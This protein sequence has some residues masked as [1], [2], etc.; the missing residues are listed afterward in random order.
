MNLMHLGFRGKYEILCNFSVESNS[1]AQ[2][3]L[4]LKLRLYKQDGSPNNFLY[5]EKFEFDVWGIL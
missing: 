4:G 2:N 3:S 5:K 1:E